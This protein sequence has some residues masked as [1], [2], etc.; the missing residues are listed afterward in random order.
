MRHMKLLLALLVGAGLVGC[1]DDK[2]SGVVTLTKDLC[3][4]P[5]SMERLEE[6]MTPPGQPGY[7]DIQEEQVRR[8]AA[9]PTEGPFYMLNLIRYRELAVYRWIRCHTN[10]VIR[11]RLTTGFA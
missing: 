7:G 6:P 10:R 4:D 11:S 2:N 5:A 9:A 8:M 1:A 3:L